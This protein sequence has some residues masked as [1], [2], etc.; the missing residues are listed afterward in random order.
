MDLI[1]KF[2]VN[3]FITAEFEGKLV[4]CLFDSVCLESAYTF[5]FFR[6]IEDCSWLWRKQ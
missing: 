2:D 3:N 6:R 4:I 1:N 5:D